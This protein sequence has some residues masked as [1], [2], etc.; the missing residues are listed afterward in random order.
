MTVRA[1]GTSDVRALA[2]RFSP[3]RVASA[4][5]MDAE[6]IRTLARDFAKAERAV[7]YG[8]VGLCTQELGGLGS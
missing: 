7:C 3:E 1:A 8:R 4:T 2:E 6:T 5:G